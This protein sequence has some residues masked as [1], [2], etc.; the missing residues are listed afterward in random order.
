MPASGRAGFLCFCSFWHK[1]LSDSWS[2]CCIP[3]TCDPEVIPMSCRVESTL[4]PLAAFAGLRDTILKKKNLS[5][6][7]KIFSE[8]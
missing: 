6:S 2:W 8:P 4:E 7:F 5:S 3:L 1:T